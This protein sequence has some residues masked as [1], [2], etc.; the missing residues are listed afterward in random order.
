MTGWR[1]PTAGPP[2]EHHHG[3]AGSDQTQTAALHSTRQISFLFG[4]TPR[5]ILSPATPPQYPPKLHPLTIRKPRHCHVQIDLGRSPGIW[6]VRPH[7]HVLGADLSDQM[8]Q[9]L[10]RENQ[11]VEK[12]LATAEMRRRRL[13]L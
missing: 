4:S 3:T 11:R 9:R 12:Q 1:Q 8:A 10:G 5:L 13:F 2:V 7:T 6:I